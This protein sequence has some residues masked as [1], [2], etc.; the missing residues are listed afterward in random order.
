[1][2]NLVSPFPLLL[3]LKLMYRLRLFFDILPG[4]V[5]QEMTSKLRDKTEQDRENTAAM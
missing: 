3:K 5:T 4:N 1:M 2:S